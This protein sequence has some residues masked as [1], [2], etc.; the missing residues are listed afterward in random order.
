MGS[1]REPHGHPSPI[2]QPPE[3]ILDPVP[4]LVA[5]LVVF[6]GFV[7]GAPAGDAGLD[8]PVLQGFTKPVSVVALVGQQPSSAGQTAQQGQSAGVVAHLAGCQEEPDR[9]SFGIGH[10]VQLGVQSA[11]GAPD[12]ATAPPFFARRLE[13]VRCAFRKVASIMIVLGRSASAARP[14]EAARPSWPAER[15]AGM[16]RRRFP[17]PGHRPIAAHHP[18]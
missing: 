5:A 2:L 16:C 17:R 10:G 7:A 8:A 13:A 3:H 14:A 15:H 9:P 11:F 6:G 12:K 4:S 18:A 1:G